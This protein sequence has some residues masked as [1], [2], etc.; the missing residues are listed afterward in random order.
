M[1]AGSLHV[2][3]RVAKDCLLL[4]QYLP[5]SFNH[6]PTAEALGFSIDHISVP[7]NRGGKTP[8][9]SRVE[10]WFSGKK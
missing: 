7:G 2:I 5:F 10:G 6:S 1:Q 9:G 4:T 3:G 8:H